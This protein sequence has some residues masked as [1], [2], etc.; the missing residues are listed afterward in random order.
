MRIA[1]CGSANQGKSTLIND[2]IK[3]W[4]MYKRSNES[5]RKIIK[6][7]NI[8]VNKLG[9]KHGQKVILDC[10]VDDIN[11]TKKGDHVF[12][13]RCPL[14]NLV[15]SLWA[16]DK[17]NSDIDKSF[18][19]DCIDIVKESMRKIDIIFFLPITRVA[20]VPLQVRE[21]RDLDPV[22]IAEID[23]IFKAIQYQQQRG[24][25]PF[26]VKDDAPPI[27]EIFGSPLERVEL[28]KLYINNV[29]DL[30]DTASSVLNP[31]NLEMMEDLLRQQG[32]ALED[33]KKQ[34]ALVNKII[35]AKITD[36]LR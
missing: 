15:Y 1:I 25:A 34:E 12:F 14:D 31:E 16:S 20:P 5:Y 35:K 10:L 2:M 28:A 13:D 26:F 22:F 4:P 27:I 36:K 18:V 30:I 32:Y 23:N 17:G 9:T 19:D 33:E 24:L 8:P 29:G 21:G 7:Q 6:E 3:E 11:Q